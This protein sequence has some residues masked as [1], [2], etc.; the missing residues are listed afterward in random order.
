[1]RVG[2]HLLVDVTTLTR[3]PYLVHE[4]KEIEKAPSVC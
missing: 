4:E 3:R 1:M 2:T